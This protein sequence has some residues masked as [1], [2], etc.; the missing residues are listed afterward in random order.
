MTVMCC[1][2]L[3]EYKEAAQRMKSLLTEAVR[4]GL[5]EASFYAGI[6]HYAVARGQGMS[7]ETVME[8]LEQFLD[9]EL[10]KRLRDLFEDETK[11]FV[12]QYPRFDFQGRDGKID[13][14]VCEY[15]I[16]LQTKAKMVEYMKNHPVDQKGLE[17]IIEYTG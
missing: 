6:Y 2:M 17:Q 12:R 10:I 1:V 3:R 8:Y 5:P 14:R 15:N 16:W 11:V 7:F 9:A 13:D 4:R